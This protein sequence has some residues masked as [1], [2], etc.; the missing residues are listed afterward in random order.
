MNA[1]NKLTATGTGS[2]VGFVEFGQTSD[3]ATIKSTLTIKTVSFVDNNITTTGDMTCVNVAASKN[4][5]ATEKG[6]FQQGCYSSSFY[7]TSDARLKRDVSTVTDALDKCAK[8]R[9][10]TFKWVAGEDQ[11]DQLGVIAQETQQV[12]PS[13]V[14]EHEGYLRVDYP[15]LVGLLIEAVKELDERTRPVESS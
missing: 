5:T 14:S 1:A 11:R 9:G 13:L 12:Y 7:A 8:L 2:R 4:V 10:V 3:I 6:T 15:K